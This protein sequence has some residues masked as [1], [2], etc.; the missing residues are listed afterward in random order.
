MRKKKILHMVEDLNIGGLERVVES[1]VIGLNNDKYDIEV[2][3]LAKGGTIADCL[4][5]KGINLRILGMKSYY[6][7][8][9]ILKLS[10]YLKKSRITIIHLH[11]YFGNT[12]GRLSAVFAGVPI[13]I[14]HI[15][16]TYYKF[17]KRNICI[18]KLLSYFTDKIIC[19]S[20]ATKKFV[21]EF[22]GISEKKTCL[23]YNGVSPVR[24]LSYKPNLKRISCNFSKDD[25]IAITVASLVHHK[26]HRILID[27][28]SIISKKFKNLKLFILGD[29]PLRG[30]L[31]SH[32]RDKGLESTI[33]FIGKKN[34]VFSYLKI[35]DLFILPSIEREGLGLA[36]IEAMASG[37]PLI[38]TDIGGIPEVIENNVNGI[39]IP[40]D[41]TNSL[42]EAIER[43]ITDQKLRNEMGKEGKRIFKEKFSEK[44]MIHK[45]ES[46]YDQL[47]NECGNFR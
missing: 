44:T 25:I 32:V 7:P 5:E 41:N 31:E 10:Y 18:E 3:C 43:L 28:I 20:K 2:W 1:I 8:Y 14:A 29:G 4:I 17:K 11:G 36:L 13:K 27:A 22:E 39:M 38:G 26:G 23:I 16:T 37:L 21:E 33:I 15:H 19:I 30:T 12:F 42:A 34:D 47:S 35:S 6:N 9:N 46:L 24:E 40:P 45:I